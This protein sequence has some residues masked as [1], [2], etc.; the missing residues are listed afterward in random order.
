ME[1]FVSYPRIPRDF[2]TFGV[3]VMRD[4]FGLVRKDSIVFVRI[5]SEKHFADACMGSIRMAGLPVA[6]LDHVNPTF[7]SPGPMPSKRTAKKGTI[8][9]RLG[10][11]HGTTG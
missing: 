11:L 2:E 9:T 8:T 7:R 10:R 3:A 6:A 1:I 4:E 5:L